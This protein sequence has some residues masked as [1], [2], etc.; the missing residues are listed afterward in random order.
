MGRDKCTEESHHRADARHYSGTPRLNSSEGIKYAHRDDKS[1]L[2]EA[3]EER[4][5]GAAKS[6]KG[7][8]QDITSAAAAAVGLML[9]AGYF[10]ASR[11]QEEVARGTGTSPTTPKGAEVNPSLTQLVLL[12]NLM[13]KAHKGFIELTQED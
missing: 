3:R 6:Q 11:S 4:N 12:P 10:T 2:P 7:E 5:R 13:L 9:C 8:T 1:Q